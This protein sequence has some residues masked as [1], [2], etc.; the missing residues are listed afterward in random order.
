[1]KIAKEGLFGP[2]MSILKF[3]DIEEVSQR[4]NNSVYG[5]GAG[6]VSSDMGNVFR[7]ANSLRAGTVYVNCYNVFNPVLPFGGYKNSGVGREL[8]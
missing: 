5:L 7:L 8:G 1:M 6:I 3:R 2:V 4:A